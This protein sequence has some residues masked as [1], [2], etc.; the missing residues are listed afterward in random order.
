MSP[1]ASPAIMSRGAGVSFCRARASAWACATGR[2]KNVHPSRPHAFAPGI[3]FVLRRGVAIGPGMCGAHTDDDDFV[4]GLTAFLVRLRVDGEIP[5]SLDLR[6]AKR[7]VG[8]CG[9]YGLH[10]YPFF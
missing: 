3:R 1:S 4:T 10:R 5:L 7:A 2:V 9:R 8:T 6:I